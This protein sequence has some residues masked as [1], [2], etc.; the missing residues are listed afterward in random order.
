VENAV[1]KVWRQMSAACMCLRFTHSDVV[2]H[3]VAGKYA[4][5]TGQSTSCRMMAC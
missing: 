1:Q 5:A 4:K 3:A 2:V